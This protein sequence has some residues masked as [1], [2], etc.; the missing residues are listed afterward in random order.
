MIAWVASSAE[1]SM[2]RIREATASRSEVL[3]GQQVGQLMSAADQ[4]PGQRCKELEE[5]IFLRSKT[6]P[7]VRLPESGMLPTRW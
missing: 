7:T 4:M 1:C 5:T 2:S 3:D 6:K